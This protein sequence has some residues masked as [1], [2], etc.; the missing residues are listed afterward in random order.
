MTNMTQV[1]WKFNKIS[2]EMTCTKSPLSLDKRLLGERK[3]PGSWS[4][5]SEGRKYY[6]LLPTVWR[7]YFP[8]QRHKNSARRKKCS[9]F[10]GQEIVFYERA[11]RT[12]GAASLPRSCACQSFVLGTALVAACRHWLYLSATQ[13]FISGVMLD[14]NGFHAILCGGG[15][16][17]I[18]CNPPT[19]FKF[20][21]FAESKKRFFLTHAVV[22]FVT[23]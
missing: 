4:C 20:S 23:T 12:G 3:M 18:V 15:F 13:I 1:L 7:I 16:E 6:E 22:L 14:G 21:L 19:L 11:S 10:S 9:T 8:Q 17:N 5:W 2:H